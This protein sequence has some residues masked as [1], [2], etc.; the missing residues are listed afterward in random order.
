M[1]SVAQGQQCMRGVLSPRDGT[2]RVYMPG[3]R[4]LQAHG[5]HILQFIP[6]L[7]QHFF[8]CGPVD[9]AICDRD[10]VLELRQVGWNGLLTEVNVALQH[11]A[12]K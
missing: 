8:G 4:V 1:K 2:E 10:A 6:S 3:W 5:Q 11:E 9:T 7:E 12:N